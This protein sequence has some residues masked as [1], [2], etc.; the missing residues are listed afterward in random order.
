MKEIIGIVVILI[1]VTV[2]SVLLQS[3]LEKTTEEILLK[4][5]TL[6]KNIEQAKLS[7]DNTKAKE[8]SN[9]IIEKWDEISE[10]WSMIVVHQELDNIKL[11]IL[12]VNGAIEAESFDDAIE[13][14]DKTIFLAGHIK[15]KESFRLKNI[16]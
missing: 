13:E 8:T 15:E 16:F 9:E 14:I 10:I 12:E 1:I 11:S 3:Y 6:K 2:S 7:E 4:L 5:E